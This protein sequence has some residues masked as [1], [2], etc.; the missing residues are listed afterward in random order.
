MTA[1][2]YIG[3]TDAE[4]SWVRLEDFKALAARL[5][6]L[7][8]AH[9]AELVQLF[10]QRYALERRAEAAEAR[11]A[12]AERIIREVVDGGYPFD[13][14]AD[15]TDRLEAFLRAADSADAVARAARDAVVDGRGYI[16]QTYVDPKDVTDDSASENPNG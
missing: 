14:S 8:A 7:D 15:T 3:R 10:E 2:G 5:A 12:E 9:N 16:R 11:L 13:G 6:A 4:G 1:L